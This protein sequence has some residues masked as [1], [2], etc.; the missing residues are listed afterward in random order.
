[1]LDLMGML[2][3]LRER[4]ANDVRR[5]LHLGDFNRAMLALGAEEGIS[6]VMQEVKFRQEA[7]ERIQQL[8]EQKAVRKA[9]RRITG[10]LR[11]HDVK[12]IVKKEAMNG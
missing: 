5:Y 11:A 4:K 9:P 12:S 1:M 6:L 7:D 8:R 10:V 3:D 2:N